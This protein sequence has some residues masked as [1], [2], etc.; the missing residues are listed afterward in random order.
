MARY[1]HDEWDDDD[2]ASWDDEGPYGEFAADVEVNMPCPYCGEE[3]HEDAQRCP[4]CENYISA[5][6]APQQRKP[7]WIVAGVLLCLVLVY[8]WIVGF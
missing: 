2:D 1:R 8:L 6:D 5:E 7:W 4:Y 3:I